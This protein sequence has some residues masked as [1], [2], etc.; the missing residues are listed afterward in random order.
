MERGEVGW[1]DEEGRRR[2]D[3]GGTERLLFHLHR[4]IHT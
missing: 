4:E 1:M 2:P 3:M